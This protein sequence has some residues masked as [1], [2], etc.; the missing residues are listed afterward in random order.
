MRNALGETRETLRTFSKDVHRRWPELDYATLESDIQRARDACVDHVVMDQLFPS[1][2]LPAKLYSLL[3]TA[4]RRNLELSDAFI[5]AFNAHLFAP[6][7]VLS[8]AMLETGCI[9]FDA[10]VRLED[11]I[12]SGDVSRIPD[13]D[14]HLMR[15]LLGSRTPTDGSNPNKYPAPNVLSI[16]DRLERQGS[17]SHLRD[18]YDHLSEYAHPN[19]PGLLGLY[20][21]HDPTVFAVSYTGRPMESHRDDLVHP[22]MG[23]TVGIGVLTIAV[24]RFDAMRSEVVGFCETSLGADDDDPPLT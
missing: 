16:I 3:Q 2:K 6:L 13:F 5:D 19:F 23:A 12:E 15:V 10:W 11:M 7:F 8:R 4:L 1:H 20:S 9:A 14:E 22:L 21:E 24:T 18:H 17:F